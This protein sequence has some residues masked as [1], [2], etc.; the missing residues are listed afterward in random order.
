[1]NLLFRI[2][3]RAAYRMLQ[4][5]WLVRRPH[6]YGAAV[7]IWRGDALL[8]VRTSYRPELDLPGGGIGRGEAPLAA[9]VRELCEETGI[10]AEPAELVALG[11]FHFEDNRRRIT[12]FLFTWRPPTP[13]N[14]VADQREIVWTGFV[15]LAKL[16]ETPLCKLPRLYLEALAR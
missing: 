5:W 7:A 6:A 8:V 12:T 11:E 4:V 15:P 13:V 9:A 10:E 14:P 2:A 1:M 16:A 3:Y